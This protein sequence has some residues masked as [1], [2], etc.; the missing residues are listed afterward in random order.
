MR[1]IIHNHLPA[2]DELPPNSTGKSASDWSRVMSDLRDRKP[3]PIN[4]LWNSPASAPPEQVAAAEQK[5]REWSR[6]YNFASR[7][8][9]KALEEDNENFRKQQAQR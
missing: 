8:Q 5:I 6:E 3:R 2:K 9:K 4:K 1:V 7:M